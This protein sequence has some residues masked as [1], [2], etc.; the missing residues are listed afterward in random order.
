MVIPL[1]GKDVQQLTL[2]TKQEDGTLAM[3]E[4]MPVRFT[5][6]EVG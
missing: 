5:Q 1:G 6:L 3:R 2:V 4:I